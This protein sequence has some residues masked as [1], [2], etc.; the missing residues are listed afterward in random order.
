MYTELP[1]GIAKANAVMNST[2]KLTQNVFDPRF[3]GWFILFLFF[4]GF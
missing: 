4:Q 1:F 3:T 2:R